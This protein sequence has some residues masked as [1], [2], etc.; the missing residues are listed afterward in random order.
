MTLKHSD[1]RRTTVAFHRGD[2]KR[3]TIRGILKE[4]RISVE[5]LIELL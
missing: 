2:M 5:E 3:G 1:G 4:A